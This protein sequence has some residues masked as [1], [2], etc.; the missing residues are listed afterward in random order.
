MDRK[1]IKIKIFLSCILFLCLNTAS[2]FAETM[3]AAE[4]QVARE[5]FVVGIKSQLGKPYEY[6]AVG[7]DT[8]DCSGLIYYVAKETLNKKMPRTAKAIYNDVRI[9]AEQKKEIGDIL[10]FRTSDNNTI[11]HV[12]VYIGNNK[13]ISALSDSLS[14]DAQ[15]GVAISMLDSDYWKEKYVGAGQFLPSGKA[16]DKEASLEEEDKSSEQKVVKKSSPNKKNNKAAKKASK[17]KDEVSS[18]IPDNVLF[19]ATIFFDWSL[20]SPRQ[21]V[22]RYRGI[23][24]LAHVRYSGWALEPGFGLAFR[25]NYGLKTFQMPIIFSITFN[26]YVRVYAGPVFSF[27]EAVLIDTDKQIKPSVF[28]GLVGVSFTTPSYELGSFSFQGVQDVS[29]TV[30]NNLDGATLSFMESLAAGL[31][32]YTGI[33]IAF[34]LS[35]FGRGK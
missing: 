20:L 32:M 14:A 9:V 15:T 8:F 34:P 28:P 23:D 27:K 33:R 24:A 22:F 10:F 16:D 7:P 11:S 26:D 2:L 31:V 13:F 3:T 5:K 25:Y 1:R 6:G 35:T 4:A 18:Y 29:Y 19:D 17:E 21:F 12:G 30:Y